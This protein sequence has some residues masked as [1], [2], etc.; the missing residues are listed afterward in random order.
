MKV[1]ERLFTFYVDI[2]Q[3]AKPNRNLVQYLFKKN[4][5]GHR[6]RKCNQTQKYDRVVD[7]I[8]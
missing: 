7:R 8:L 6:I 5:S 2:R 1:L 4:P 3:L